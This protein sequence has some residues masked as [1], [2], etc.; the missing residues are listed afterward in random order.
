MCAVSG[1]CV[2]QAYHTRSVGVP[3][4]ALTQVYQREACGVPALALAQA[5]H[6]RSVWCASLALAQ[7]TTREACGVI[8]RPALARSEHRRREAATQ[9]A[10]V[11]SDWVRALCSYKR[12]KSHS[13]FGKFSR[14]SLANFGAGLGVFG[15]LKP[16]KTW[17]TRWGF[18]GF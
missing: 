7:A 16:E 14:N 5:N 6:T 18:L 17:Y 9:G 8:A 2:A 11:A 15:V 3:V 12:P 1:L 10:S 13:D 4:L